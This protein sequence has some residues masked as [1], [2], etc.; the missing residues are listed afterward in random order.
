MMSWLCS[1]YAIIT[2]ISI[3]QCSLYQHL[4]SYLFD[5]TACCLNKIYFDIY[6]SYNIIK[7]IIL[8]VKLGTMIKISFRFVFKGPVD[9]M[10]TLF[11]VMAWHQ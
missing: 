11:Q 9:N 5:A 3:I 10:S 8:K 1:L 7:Y 4:T 6:F 2:I